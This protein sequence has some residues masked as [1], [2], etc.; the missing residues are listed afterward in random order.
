MVDTLTTTKL[1]S[2]IMVSG[3]STSMPAFPPK[4][5]GL[6]NS[7]QRKEEAVVP[8]ITTAPCNVE[9]LPHRNLQRHLNQ[10]FGR[11]TRRQNNSPPHDLSCSNHSLSSV[12]CSIASNYVYI[13]EHVQ[14]FIVCKP[15][16]SLQKFPWKLS[17][18]RSRHDQCLKC[19]GRKQYRRLWCKY[20]FSKLGSL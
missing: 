5:Q 13:G 10:H 20:F 11:T 15:R 8:L 7:R 19:L 17:S 4:F 2:Q 14:P 1:L 18:R 9:G 12:S 3:T 16:V 6:V